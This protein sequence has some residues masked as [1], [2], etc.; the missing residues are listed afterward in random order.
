MG[1]YHIFDLD[2]EDLQ[3]IRDA[4]KPEMSS[5]LENAVIYYSE[6]EEYQ[7]LGHSLFGALLKREELVCCVTCPH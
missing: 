3:R 7:K 1:Q 2:E 6:H 4:G 5:R